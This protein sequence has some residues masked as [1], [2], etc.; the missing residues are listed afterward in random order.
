MI[1]QVF[2]WIPA[3]GG[4]DGSAGEMDLWEGGSVGGWIFGE[5]EIILFRACFFKKFCLNV[6]YEKIFLA[7][8]LYLLIPFFECLVLLYGFKATRPTSVKGINL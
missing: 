5:G 7:D 2:L 1:S 6:K 4:N 3:Q 8:F